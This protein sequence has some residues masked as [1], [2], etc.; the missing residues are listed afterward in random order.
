MKPYVHPNY[1]TEK[2]KNIAHELKDGA[3][4]R[5]YF[6]GSIS[7]IKYS[8]IAW[9]LSLRLGNKKHQVVTVMQND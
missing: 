7:V 1:A 4:L 2:E 9:N 3:C 5:R 8:S 6:I